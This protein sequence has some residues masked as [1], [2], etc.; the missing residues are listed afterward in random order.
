MEYKTIKE[1]VELEIRAENKVSKT[2]NHNTVSVIFQKVSLSV[3]LYLIS[4]IMLFAYI[5]TKE[6]INFNVPLPVIS[7]EK[8]NLNSR[9]GQDGQAQQIFERFFYLKNDFEV[10]RFVVDHSYLN[11]G[12]LENNEITAKIQNFVKGQN[13][14]LVYDF[15]ILEVHQLRGDTYKN[16]KENSIFLTSSLYSFVVKQEELPRSGTQ[17][18]PDPKYY[19]YLVDFDSLM[20]VRDIKE[21]PD[22]LLATKYRYLD[23]LDS[24]NPG[25]IKENI[26]LNSPI[27]SLSLSYIDIKSVKFKDFRISKSIDQTPSGTFQ[28]KINNDVYY[29]YVKPS[30]TG[31][32]SLYIS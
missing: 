24:I 1:R 18:I 10:Q 23:F 27:S 12:D 32:L 3:V 26:T 29:G 14:K 8:M 11:E 9:E 4:L 30:P 22:D 6:A 7:T 16:K 19:A 25:N 13:S 28:I 15:K 2:Q 5:T 31:D 21:S 20:K 17:I